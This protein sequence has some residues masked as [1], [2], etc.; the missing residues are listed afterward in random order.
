MCLSVKHAARCV[1]EVEG[2]GPADGEAGRGFEPT[3]DSLEGY[4]P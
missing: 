2:V 4:V 1:A 3:L